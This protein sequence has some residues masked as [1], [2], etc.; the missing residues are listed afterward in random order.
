MYVIF[1]RVYKNN[2]VLHITHHTPPSH[3]HTPK[4][5]VFE[6]W[7]WRITLPGDAQSFAL[8]YSIEDP[9]GRTKF[10][11]VGAQIMGPDDGYLLQ[12]SKDTSP[13][14]AARQSLALGCVFK[15]KPAPPNAPQLNKAAGMMAAPTFDAAVAEGFQASATWHQGRIVRQEAGAAGALTSTV[16]HCS[17]AFSV[18]PSSGWGASAGGRQ[19]ATAGWLASLPVFE[20]HW[21]VLM[22][23]GEATGWIDWGGQRYDFTSA[24]AYAEKNW[25]GGFPTRWCWIQ[26]N[27]FENSSGASPGTSVT[28]VGARRG[29]LQVP[30]FQEDVGMIGIHHQGQFYELNVKDSEVWW[31]VS[32]WGRWE[33]RGENERLE[34]VVEATCDAPGTPLR[35]PTADQGLA[36]F[37]RDSFAGVVRIRVWDKTKS[38]LIMDVQS[39][40]RSGAVEVGGGPW[41]SGWQAKAA[42]SEPVKRLLN[43]P[44]DV[45]ALAGLV[46]PWLKPPG[47]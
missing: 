22:A 5:I 14:W 8:I 34:A 9:L 31:D 3:K 42:M 17:W 6:G 37:C 12:Y 44:V 41:W 24:P 43:L 35:A 18:H 11:G 27:S 10:S 38:S 7:Y 15:E 46:P 13:F 32:P 16:P 23:H 20:P 47:L 28:A 2:D 1:P 33:I 29:L 39:R 40:G 21:Q 45:E 4:N 36:P 30:G 19:R 26:C 25:G